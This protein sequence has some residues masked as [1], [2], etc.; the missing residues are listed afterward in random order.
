MR[1]LLTNDDGFGSVG[2]RALDEV[3]TKAGHEVWV[4]APSEHKSSTSHSLSFTD[5]KTPVEIEKNRYS[6]DGQPAD[7]IMTALGRKTISFE[8][9]VVI[10]GINAGFN[11]SID[12]LYSGTFGA[13]SEAALWGYKAIAI[14]AESSQDKNIYYSAATFLSEH[15]DGF[16]S[17]MDTDCVLNINMPLS[18]DGKSWSIGRCFSL[19]HRDAAFPNDKGVLLNGQRDIEKGIE[20]SDLALC[21]KGLI[22]VTPISVSPMIPSINV[23]KLDLMLASSNNN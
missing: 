3:L 12:I 8:P 11:L 14:S 23:D 9:D 21:A 5:G 7:C 18:S 2:I 16:L 17:I 15:L 19:V 10:S 13:A 20:D 4:C 1:I 6:F 22:S